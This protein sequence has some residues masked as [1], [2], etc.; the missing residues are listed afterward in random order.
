MP[1]IK[2]SQQAIDSLQCPD[3]KA[4]IEYCDKN[5]TG[6]YVLVSSKSNIKSYFL[7]YK[8]ASGKTCHQKLGRTTDI[9]LDEARRRAKTLKAELL[10]GIDRWANKKARKAVLSFDVFFREHYLPHTKVHNRGWKKK[11]QL[12]DLR[13]KEK[14]GS[15]R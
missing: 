13:L 10:L 5:M 4:R 15:K 1:V 8:D 9:D 3:S 11:S 14:F 7:R 2:L 12:Y 6:L